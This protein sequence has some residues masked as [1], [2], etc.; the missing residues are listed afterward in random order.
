MTTDPPQFVRFTT[1][2]ERLCPDDP[3]EIARTED[4]IYQVCEDTVELRL[5]KLRRLIRTV[6]D[7]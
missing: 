7:E 2:H 1:G 6:N 3:A 4:E 5:R